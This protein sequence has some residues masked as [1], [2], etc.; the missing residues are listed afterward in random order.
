MKH[1]VTIV[2]NLETII[3]DLK[4]AFTNGRVLDNG[5]P[6]KRLGYRPREMIPLVI[7]TAIQNSLCSANKFYIATDPEG[8]DGILTDL[9]IKEPRNFGVE[10]VYIGSMQQGELTKLI[11]DSVLKKEAKGIEY[12][13]NRNLVIFID[14][15]G[16]L[17][18]PLLAK[19]LRKFK[20]FDSYTL[21]LLES[22]NNGSWLKYTVVTLKSKLE[23]KN[24][25]SISIDPD[26][27]TYECEHLGEIKTTL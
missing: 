18:K 5:R 15:E 20:N 22:H 4:P 10:Q 21:I 9:D 3:K 12:G 23:P 24:I 25:F 1:K 2:K 27:G 17:D 7:L 11:I 19:Y 8:Y 13:S 26:T 6:D 16:Q 14:K